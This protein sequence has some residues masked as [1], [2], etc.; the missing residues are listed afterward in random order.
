M[1]REFVTDKR[2]G[3]KQDVPTEQKEYDR[4]KKEL[5]FKPDI[6]KS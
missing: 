1:V 4:A 3:R 2:T 6:A 5:S